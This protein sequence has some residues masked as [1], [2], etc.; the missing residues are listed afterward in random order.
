[1]LQNIGQRIREIRTLRGIS[2]NE[3]ARQLNVSAGY[4]SNL[5]TGKTDTIHLSLLET[6]QK[7]LMILPV[8]SENKDLSETSRRFN[9]AKQE[10]SLLEKE[11][12]EAAEYLVSSLEHGIHWFLTK[13]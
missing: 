1:M 13:R 4:L 7:E 3:F 10:I 8:A 2:L 6:L 12:P 5:E 11:N 9:S